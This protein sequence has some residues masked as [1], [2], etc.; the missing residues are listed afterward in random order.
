MWCVW[1]VGR[2]SLREPLSSVVIAYGFLIDC[3]M[4]SAIPTASH[5]C[6]FC[7]LAVP[8]PR[9]DRS[10]LQCGEASI[11]AARPSSDR[12]TLLWATCNEIQVS[13]RQS[14][15]KMTVWQCYLGSCRSHFVGS[16]LVRNIFPKSI[17]VGKQIIER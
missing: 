8:L 2:M 3:L 5:W 6:C 11:R 13:L 17:S 9:L 10:H 1:G 14:Q 15:R 16:I 12:R 7:R 4:G